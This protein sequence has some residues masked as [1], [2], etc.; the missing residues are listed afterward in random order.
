MQMALEHKHNAFMKYCLS[1]MVSSLQSSLPY[2]PPDLNIMFMNITEIFGK[3]VN[4]YRGIRLIQLLQI[5]GIFP[6][7]FGYSKARLLC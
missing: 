5:A 4:I 1:I 3:L 7:H 2:C 6:F